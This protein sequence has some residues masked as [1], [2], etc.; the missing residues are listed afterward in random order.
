MRSLQVRCM[1]L[2]S[3]IKSLL[4]VTLDNHL[5]YGWIDQVGLTIT[6]AR[7]FHK[8]QVKGEINDGIQIRRKPQVRIWSCDVLLILLSE[9]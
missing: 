6:E 3:S 8:I 4:A 5:F 9:K 7:D 2:F 1:H